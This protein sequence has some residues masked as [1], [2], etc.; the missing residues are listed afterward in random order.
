MSTWRERASRY[1]LKV[2]EDEDVKQIKD[3]DEKMDYIRR[4]K[5]PWG[6]RE[7]WPYKVWLKVCKE[8]KE[9]LKKLGGDMISIYKGKRKDTNKWIN[10]YLIKKR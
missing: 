3:I 4:E 8:Y 10:G 9:I 2:L 7:Y 1:I 6:P 5:Y